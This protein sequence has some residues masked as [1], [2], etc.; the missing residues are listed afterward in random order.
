LNSLSLDIIP[1]GTIEKKVEEVE[2][3]TPNSQDLKKNSAK[4]E[5]GIK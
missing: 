4:K 1:G 5:K 2:E 3:E